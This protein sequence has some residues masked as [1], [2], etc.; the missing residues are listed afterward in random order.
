[1]AIS[2]LRPGAIDKARRLRRRAANLAANLMGS[3]F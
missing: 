2:A 1:L 3:H